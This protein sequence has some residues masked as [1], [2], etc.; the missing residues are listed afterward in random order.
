MRSGLVCS[1]LPHQDVR[2]VLGVV[3]RAMQTLGLNG[4][5]GSKGIRTTIPSGDR[6]GAADLLHRQFRGDEPNAVWVTE[7]THRRTWAGP[8]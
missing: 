5:G 4:I 8:W 7:F 6:I 3:D 2:R 1:G